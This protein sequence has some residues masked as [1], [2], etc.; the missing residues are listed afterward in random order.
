MISDNSVGVRVEGVHLD[1]ANAW[2]VNGGN[3]DVSL[4]TP[5]SSPGVSND[6]VLN[7]VLVSVTNGSDGVVEVSSAVS[8]VQDSTSVALEDV[9]V[10]LNGHGDWLLGNGSLE[11]VN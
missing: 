9:L 2:S 7:T 4:V 6:V 8:R 11:L 3:L 10:G 5:S 1:T